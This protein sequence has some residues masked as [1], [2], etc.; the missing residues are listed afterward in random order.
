MY[1]NIELN[2][3]EMLLAYSVGE[4][5]TNRQTVNAPGALFGRVHAV[6]SLMPAEAQ[7]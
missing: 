3:I 1:S 5:P 2:D 6:R 4:I 7:R